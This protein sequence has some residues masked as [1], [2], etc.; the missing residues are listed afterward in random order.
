MAGRNREA[1][2]LHEALREMHMI[3]EKT[4]EALT[5]ANN[6]VAWLK[7]KLGF[8][9]QRMDPEG[10]RRELQ[11]SV[12]IGDVLRVSELDGIDLV[13]RGERGA[14]I[15]AAYGYESGDAVVVKGLVLHK[16]CLHCTSHPLGEIV[17]FTPGKLLVEVELSDGD[18]EVMILGVEN[19]GKV[20]AE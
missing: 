14:T 19:I 3:V 2:E 10:F 5:A 20:D 7:G 6:N 11:H 18:S 8:M 12:R 13:Q 9:R 4:E 17:G 15:T 16:N 1:Q